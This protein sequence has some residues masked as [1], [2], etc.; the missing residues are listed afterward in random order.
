MFT[1]QILIEYDGTN[2]VGWQK[3]DNGNSIQEVIEKILKKI[4]KQKVLLYGSGRTDA[5]VHAIEQSAHFQTNTNIKD[6]YKFI[7]SINYFLNKK[8]ISIKINEEDNSGDISNKLS[9][10]SSD[11]IVTSLDEIFKKNAKFTEQEHEKATY[12][13]KISKDESRIDWNNTSKTILAKI[14]SL[15]PNPGAWFNFKN[16]RFKIWK[17]EISHEIGKPGEILHKNFTIGCKDKSLKILE[18]QK[19]GK[20]RLFIEEFLK[21]TNINTGDVIN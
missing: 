6:R 3:Q 18:I 12:A 19:E 5:G 4:L 21:G 1:Y 2:F 13:E 20:K 11:N 17:A 10:I 15:N 9:K 8:K 7:N 16:S 14:N